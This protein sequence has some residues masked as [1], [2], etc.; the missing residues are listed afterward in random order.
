[1]MLMSDLSPLNINIVAA[2][3]A[4]TFDFQVFD[5]GFYSEGHTLF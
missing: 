5:P 1:M 3:F 2:I 4:T